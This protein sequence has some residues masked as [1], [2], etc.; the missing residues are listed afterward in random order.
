VAQRGCSLSG[1]PFACAGFREG[2]KRDESGG[3]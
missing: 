2:G 1:S 3:I